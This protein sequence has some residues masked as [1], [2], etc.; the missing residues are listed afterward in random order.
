M[1]AAKVKSQLVSTL[2][3]LNLLTGAC[4]E[5]DAILRRLFGHRE[6]SQGRQLMANST[7]NYVDVDTLPSAVE[8]R[9]STGKRPF[10]WLLCFQCRCFMAAADIL[11][12][13]FSFTYTFSPPTTHLIHTPTKTSSSHGKGSTSIQTSSSSASSLA[14]SSAIP[15]STSL[16][17]S[18]HSSPSRSHGQTIAS[19][20]DRS[21][22]S[23]SNG[24]AT[25]LS[26]SSASP[27]ESTSSSS[28][29]AT[30]I[31]TTSLNAIHH[32]HHTHHHHHRTTSEKSEP[33]SA[34]GT[35]YPETSFS[36]TW[37]VLDSTTA[38]TPTSSVFNTGAPNGT[39][40]L[41]IT[42]RNSFTS[43]PLST[44]SNATSTPLTSHPSS[45]PVMTTNT[46]L[47]FS[48]SGPTTPS[49]PPTSSLAKSPT[50]F[51]PERHRIWYHYE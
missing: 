39:V 50:P 49:S 16:S 19:S 38:Q 41:N 2:A 1:K 3:L 12:V 42:L 37:T 35:S 14:T 17:L 34:R 6:R 40:S 15:V 18:L 20:S 30:E 47:S 46:S 4:A 8:E 33:T 22:S 27:H 24:E 31:A 36:T 26:S 28:W 21:S 11:P 45:V 23:K 25:T 9:T 7:P 13:Q 48:M 10:P 44:L 43:Y 5:R 51:Y 32:H 29:S